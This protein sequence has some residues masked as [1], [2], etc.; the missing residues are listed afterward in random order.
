MCRSKEE[1]KEIIKAM[2]HEERLAYAKKLKAAGMGMVVSGFG[3]MGGLIGGLWGTMGAGAIGVGF[4][5]ASGLLFGSC[6]PFQ[7]AKQALEWDKEFESDQQ[8]E[9]TI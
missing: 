2:T 6:G 1:R 5:S 7:Y 3:T 4:G 9:A 8:K